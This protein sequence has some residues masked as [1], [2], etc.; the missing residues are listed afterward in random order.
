MFKLFKQ[1]KS[2]QAKSTGWRRHWSPAGVLVATGSSKFGSTNIDSPL[3]AGFMTQ[4]VDDGLAIETEEG[5]LLGWDSLYLA[6]GQPSYAALQEQLQLPA[7]TQARP[8]LR[9]SQ[10]LADP[11]FSIAIAGWHLDDGAEVSGEVTGP[12]LDDGVKQSLMHQQ[13]WALFK[14]VVAFARRPEVERDDLVHRQ[15]W[16]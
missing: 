4:L 3:L 15:A 6:I 14:E 13:Q 9:S 1:E 8:A 10:S 12:L 11:D 2:D 5:F 7:F 16:G